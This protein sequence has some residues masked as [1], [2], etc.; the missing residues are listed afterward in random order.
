MK[1]EEFFNILNKRLEMI[2]KNELEDILEEY[3][4]HI[5]MK[6]QSGV[7]EE[8]AIKDFGNVNTLAD[9]ILESYHIRCDYTKD[10]EKKQGRNY[11]GTFLDSLKR[12]YSSFLAILLG[13]CSAVKR[14]FVSIFSKLA[15]FF[16]KGK[17][18]EAK[19][20][21]ENFTQQENLIQQ[22]N[23]ERRKAAGEK[24]KAFEKKSKDI[25]R[26]TGR[27]MM[28]FFRSL[29]E[30][31]I[32]ILRM[33]I[34]ICLISAG[35]VTG[36]FAALALFLLGFLIIMLVTGYPVW[37]MTITALGVSLSLSSLTILIFS[38]MQLKKSKAVLNEAEALGND[39][40]K[41]QTSQQ[42][43]E[44]REENKDEH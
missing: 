20:P 15:A 7:S 9:E 24:R 29:K 37:G 32:W 4:Q 19:E 35:S 25:C 18:S 34:N 23:I 30:F 5:D 13:A 8:E 38:F 39:S 17:N 22:K 1:R 27:T 12:G 11:T 41:G 31:F 40:L 16:K 14:F 2:E 33:F 44:Q 6:I 42:N 28:V 26:G 3:R 36:I 43:I 10:K 21:Q